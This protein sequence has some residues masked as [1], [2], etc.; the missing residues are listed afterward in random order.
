[1]LALF[2]VSAWADKAG[3]EDEIKHYAKI[4]SGNSFEAHRGAIGDLA[5]LG[6]SDARVYDPLEKKVLE[7]YMDDDKH[8][9]EAVSWYVKGLAL[10]GKNKYRATMEKVLAES[11]SKKIKKHTTKALDRLENYINWTPIISAGL[12]GAPAGQ[13]GIKR[14]HNMLK[15]S[16]LELQRTGAKRIF[17]EYNTEQELLEVA[18]DTLLASYKSSNTDKLWIDTMAWHCKA[19]GS[20]GD[21]KYRAILEDV[22]ANASNS[23]LKK[24]AKKSLKSF[25]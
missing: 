11:N 3:L 21:E 18:K 8:T 9:V 15:S 10:S 22:L 1:M 4:F 23:K 14:A 24:Y 25:K 5:W 16:I 7:K 19:L 20:S 6:I 2:S 17:Y 12:K 13:L